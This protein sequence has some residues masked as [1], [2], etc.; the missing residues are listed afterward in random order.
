MQR[1]NI[2]WINEENEKNKD[3]LKKLKIIC[4]TEIESFKNV[5]E[6]I[7]YLK[8]IQF[9]ETK[10]IIDGNLYEDFID[11]FQNEINSINVIPKICIYTDNKEQFI[12]DNKDNENII[13]DP[14]Y[15]YGGIITSFDEI[16]NFI[17]N[18][19]ENEKFKIDDEPQLTFEYID[20]KEKLA[21]PLFYKTL[22]EITDIDKIQKYNQM[23]YTKY[24]K[25]KKLEEILN[26]ILAIPNIPIQLLSKYYVRIYS[27]E[28]DFYKEL[29]ND[30]RKNKKENYLPYVKTLYE[31]IKL[32]T[33]PLV[34]EKELYRGSKISYGEIKKIKNYLDKKI[35]NLPGA[36]VFSRTFLSFSKEKKLL[37]FF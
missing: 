13:N 10:I 21:L 30:L 27:L 26:H 36:I 4:N 31:S 15:N 34:K 3:I 24:S 2:I 29:N 14:F 12:E 22:I 16:K 35:E 5:K 6:S 19:L 33:F 8:L 11:L 7:K 23:I 17:T 28:S 9:E 32:K 18:E 20:K 1:T 37:I 25:N